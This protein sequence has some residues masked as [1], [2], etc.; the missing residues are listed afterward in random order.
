MKRTKIWLKRTVNIAEATGF[1]LL[2]MM[3]APGPVDSNVA[4]ITIK[5]S[6]PF[7]TTSCT[8]TA[9]LKESIKDRTIIADV[10]PTL[11]LRIR[12]HI[13]GCDFCQEVDIFVRVELCHFKLARRFGALDEDNIIST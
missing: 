8:D 13:V 2:C 3:E 1:A 12:V 6:R 7:H 9:E 11:F 10:V 4:F 5:P